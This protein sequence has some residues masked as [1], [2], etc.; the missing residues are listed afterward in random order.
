MQPLWRHL[1]ARRRSALA[2]LLELAGVSIM[3][4]GAWLAWEPAGWIV[5]GALAVVLA[6]GLGGEG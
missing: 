5:G 2:V 6:Q 4:Y 1:L 3:A